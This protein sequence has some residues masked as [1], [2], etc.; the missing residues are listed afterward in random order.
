MVDSAPNFE[1]LLRI[2]IEHEVE[3]IVVGG[4][5][6]V[7][8][9]APVATFDLDIVHR[10]TPENIAR[11]LAALRT[12]DA[13]YRIQDDRVIVPNCSFLESERHQLLMTNHGPLDVLGAIGANRSYED[14]FELAVE[15][16]VGELHLKILDLKSLIEIKE[17]IGHLKDRAVLEI[18]RQT[19]KERGD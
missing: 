9:G 8:Q 4:V 11:L 6:A 2:L 15:L 16:E 17:E 13:R 7:L 14:I 5:S 12:L 19:L 10:R 1:Q 3:F 18:L